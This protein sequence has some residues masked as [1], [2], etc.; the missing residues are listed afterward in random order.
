MRSTGAGAVRSARWP[1]SGSAASGT[2][3]VIDGSAE[4]AL[5]HPAVVL[6]L[7]H[8]GHREHGTRDRTSSTRPA[9]LGMVSD[10]P[11]EKAAMGRAV[12]RGRDIR[13]LH[14]LLRV[15]DRVPLR[16][17]RTTTTP[18]D[19][20]GRS[21]YPSEGGPDNCTHG[22]KGCTLCTRA[23]PRFR[24]W[25]TEIDTYLFGRERTDEEVSGVCDDM[26]L[27]RATDPEV[28][29]AG[30]DGGFVS[31]LL[32]WA[33]EHDVI[34]AALVSALEGDGSTW[35]AVP[36]VARSRADVLATAG[37]RYTYSANPI[38]YAEAIEGGRRADRPR[39]HG[40]PGVGTAGHVGAQGR[41]GGAPLHSVDRAHVL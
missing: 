31:A 41:Q 35:K 13:T 4:A 22:V 33:L 8:L 27:V 18:M 30:Q 25:E 5:G 3:T 17:A 38:A 21:T 10:V 14:R 26:V 15:R 32:I 24:N 23:C 1:P 12:H 11:P 34:D 36:A 9:S 7:Q 16:R 6:D 28:P 37:S 20:T 29:A 19:A 39:G 40:L 2:G